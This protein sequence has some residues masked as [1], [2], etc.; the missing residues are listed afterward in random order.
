MNQ[1]ILNNINKKI[2]TITGIDLIKLGEISTNFFE[3]VLSFKPYQVALIIYACS[4]SYN[5]D[6]YGNITL[7][8]LC[9]KGICHRIETLT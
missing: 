1:E 7:E 3:D 5:I 8:D 6:L 9:L 2:I 4:N